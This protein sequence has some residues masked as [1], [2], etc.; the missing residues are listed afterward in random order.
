MIRAVVPSTPATDRAPRWFWGELSAISASHVRD[1]SA[2]GTPDLG[3]TLDTA[4]V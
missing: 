3:P 4:A 2:L 1:R